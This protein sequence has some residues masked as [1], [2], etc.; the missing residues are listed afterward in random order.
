MKQKSWLVF[1]WLRLLFLLAMGNIV[2][3]FALWQDALL[4]KIPLGIVS[5]MCYLFCQFAHPHQLSNHR[6]L[7][8]L[9]HGVQLLRTGLL[10]F[11][12]EIPIF[13]AILFWSGLH[14]AYQIVNGV[15]FLLLCGILFWN[16][17]L[18]LAFHAKQVTLFWKIALFLWWWVPVLNI[19]LV[20]HIYKTANREL[21]VETEKAEL[22]AVRCESQICH[23]KYPILMVHGI[24]FRDW[25]YFNYWGRIPAELIRNGAVIHYG[26]QQS[27]QSIEDSA[28][29]L[30]AQIRTICETTGCEKLNIIAHSKG[31]LDCRCAIQD[32]GV[33]PYVASLTTINTPHHGCQF[34]DVL[35]EKVPATIQNWLAA[36]YNRI[37]HALGDQKPDFLRGVKDL[38][39]QRCQAFLQ[40]HPV[41]GT[42]AYMTVM[43]KMQ[44]IHAAPFPL[45]LGYLINKKHGA[46][47]NDGLVPVESAKLEGVPFVM[48]PKTKK[49][50]ISHGDVIDLMRENIPD[51]DVREWYVQ[52][53]KRLKENGF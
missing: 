19:V 18:H 16:A 11:C 44:S 35:L 42:V 38:T 37:F 4:W 26:N 10:W 23:T 41:G 15:V 30:A 45:W 7:A 46:A 49:R 22:D 40:S 34:V 25:Q 36:R 43:S 12:L 50:G 20:W 53:V 39:Q 14:Q 8:S 5:S 2:A 51:Y 17:L 52:F 1:R 27:A 6:K 24:F 31:G 32:F 13:L 33:Q 21:H 29:E 48:M 3:L 47:E 28:R 9:A